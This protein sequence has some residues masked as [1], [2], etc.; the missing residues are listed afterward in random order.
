[1][2]SIFLGAIGAL[3]V[4]GPFLLG[5]VIGVKTLGKKQ[6]DSAPAPLTPDEEERRRLLED[7]QAFESLLQYNTDVVYGKSNSVGGDEV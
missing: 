7:Q 5:V 6:Q 4:L 3:I 2:E 1:M